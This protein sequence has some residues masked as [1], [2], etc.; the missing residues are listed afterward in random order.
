[1]PLLPNFQSNDQTFQLLQTRW[2]AILNPVL[3]DVYDHDHNGEGLVGAK[4][5]ANNLIWDNTAINIILPSGV[6]VPFAGTT[7]PSG[8]LLCDGSVVAQ[9]SYPGLYA[10]IGATYNTG[11]EGAGNFRLPDTRGIFI[12]GAG[13][14]TISGISY[15]RTLGVKQGDLFQ[16]HYHS[17]TGTVGG[18]DGTHTHSGLTMSGTA[19]RRINAYSSGANGAIDANNSGTGTLVV[20]ST[21]SGHGHAHS[22]T[23]DTLQ[24]GTNGTP[25][26]GAETRPANIAMN[27]I[28]KV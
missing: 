20:S 28:I 21:D 19:V 2:S 10:A 26:S 23:A 8:W 6:V 25:R 14:Q 18:S 22:L 15:G 3:T 4:I 13:S 7:A 12:S 9:V 11:G 24:T 1:M 5:N 16:G 17:V 27:Y